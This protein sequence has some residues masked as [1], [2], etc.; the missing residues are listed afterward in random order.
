MNRKHLNLLTLFVVM[1]LSASVY[2]QTP[3][4][5]R[6]I[7]LPLDPDGLVH[8]NRFT[9]EVTIVVPL[10]KIESRG[11]VGFTVNETISLMNKSSGPLSIVH[12]SMAGPGLV[13]GSRAMSEIRGKS[14]RTGDQIESLTRLFFY[15]NDGNVIEF[16]DEASMGRTHRSICGESPKNRGRI[17]LA[18]DDSGMSFIADNDLFDA[19]CESS[20]SELFAPSGSLRDR[21]GRTFRIT[22]GAITLIQDRNGNQLKIDGTRVT[23]SIGRVYEIERDRI[24]FKGFGGH[25][26]VIEIKRS[27][28]T[29]APEVRSFSERHALKR[30]QSAIENEVVSE[31]IF[32]SGGKLEFMYSLHGEP[33][34][35]VSSHGWEVLLT[36]ETNTDRPNFVSDPQAENVRDLSWLSSFEVIDKSSGDIRSRSKI[37]FKRDTDDNSTLVEEVHSIADVLFGRQ[38]NLFEGNFISEKLKKDTNHLHRR[39]AGVG[40]P[41]TITTSQPNSVTAETVTNLDWENSPMAARCAGCEALAFGERLSERRVSYANSDDLSRQTFTN[42]SLGNLTDVRTFQVDA[43]GEILLRRDHCEFLKDPRYISREGPHLRSLPAACWASSDEF[44]ESK[45][46]LVQYKYDEMEQNELVSRSNV[47]GHNAADFGIRYVTRG[48]LTRE[49]KFIE[50]NSETGMVFERTQYDVLGNSV[51]VFDARGFSS[52]VSYADRFG[53]LAGSEVFNLTPNE[54]LGRRAF[55]FPSVETNNVGFRNLSVWDF[56]SGKR[57]HLTDWN[58]IARP[59]QVDSQPTFEFTKNLSKIETISRDGRLFVLA[60]SSENGKLFT[61][62]SRTQELKLDRDDSSISFVHTEGVSVSGEFGPGIS[63]SGQIDALKRI[64]NLSVEIRSTDGRSSSYQK[65]FIYDARGNLISEMHGDRLR[66]FRYD[67]LSRLISRRD[68]ESGT[69]IFEYDENNN[70]TL[71][72]DES[73]RKVV[74]RFDAMNRI[75][76]RWSVDSSG[77]MKQLAEFEYDRS[78]RGKGFLTRA[79]SISDQEE[80]FSK[81]VDAYDPNG[82]PVMTSYSLNGRVFAET[83]NEYAEDGALRSVRYASGKLVRMSRAGDGIGT[84][85]VQIA[86]DSS[87]ERLIAKNIVDTDGLLS[88]RTARGL[89]ITYRETSEG[90]RHHAQI[91]SGG[92]LISL[93]EI[94]SRDISPSPSVQSHIMRTEE[95]IRISDSFNLSDALEV[96]SDSL[97]RMLSRKTI[98][99]YGGFNRFFSYDDG[100]NRH[101]EEATTDD[102]PRRCTSGGAPIFCAEE[103]HHFFPLFSSDNRITADQDGDGRNEY[104][105]DAAGRMTL[106]S[107]GRRFTYDLEGRLSEIWTDNTRVNLLRDAFGKIVGVRDLHSGISNYFI[108]DQEGRLLAEF[109]TTDAPRKRVELSH[110]IIGAMNSMRARVPSDGSVIPTPNTSSIEIC[111]EL[112]PECAVDDVANR[113]LGVLVVSDENIF[114]GTTGR[115]L[116]P[117]F[118]FSNA[119]LVSIVPINPY[120]RDGGSKKTY[121]N[122]FSVDR[123]SEAGYRIRSGKGYNEANIFRIRKDS[124]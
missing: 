52:T 69:T 37:E 71:F 19:S 100:G 47:F 113:V 119:R 49:I 57:I 13:V 79:D 14:A 30:K 66:E 91:A 39:S 68:P 42:D 48:N 95:M 86:A 24:S 72:A 76:S 116:A 5:E 35:I 65:S 62:F 64:R 44:G 34:K 59:T 94:L 83:A 112:F 103:R 41:K 2:S 50:P 63:F 90:L 104:E 60:Q 26:R 6:N 74:T 22:N 117:T 12:Q 23:D 15:K 70:P 55:A 120:Q 9:G 43:R 20:S 53:G 10:L 108:R 110:A 17:F 118:G 89:E 4:A 111:F 107:L 78:I 45:E 7:G 88:F 82:N 99:A 46:E 28:P 29:A 109:S 27:R 101:T 1:F 38:T 32:P 106:D 33:I 11:E 96:E 61:D 97:G 77:D 73:G 87:S 56:H 31:I 124:P 67:G 114:D 3:P 81:K 98:D 36:Y 121:L 92:A 75:V 102:I 51:R 8:L 84:Q 58:G 85:I 122:E 105:Y 18:S 40:L 16:I 93:F 21:N 25:Q 115:F 123:K 80:R 54:L